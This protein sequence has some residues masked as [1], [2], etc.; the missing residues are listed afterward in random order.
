MMPDLPAYR[1]RRISEPVEPSARI[2][3]S[4]WI[5]SDWIEDFEGDPGQNGALPAHRFLRAACRWDREHL[6]V[7]FASAPSL[8]PVTKTERDDDL[9]NECAVE[10]F[11]AAGQ[12][13]YEFEINPLGAMLDLY[14]PHEDQEADWQTQARWD[15][16]D[17]KWTAGVASAGAGWNAQMCLAWAA[18]PRVNREEFDGCPCLRGNFCRSGKRQDGSYEPASWARVEARYSELNAMGYILLTE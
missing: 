15:A 1:C 8:V 9:F 14:C 3:R 16:A 13:F 7:A 11:L 12:G 5:A 6:Y 2:D 10:L 17:L 4:P 18:I